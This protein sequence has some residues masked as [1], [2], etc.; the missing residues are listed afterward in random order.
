M[1]AGL[2]VTGKVPYNGVVHCASRIFKEEGPLRF[3]RGYPAY[4]FRCCPHGLIILISRE[5]I[6][7]SYNSIF[8]LEK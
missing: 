5:Y 6:V 2:Q 1:R 7:Q 8:G 4:F 3:W